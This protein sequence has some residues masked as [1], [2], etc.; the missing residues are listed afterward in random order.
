M[1]L[2]LVPLAP[3]PSQGSSRRF[4]LSI[5]KLILSICDAPYLFRLGTAQKFQGLGRCLGNHGVD[6][7]VRLQFT[8]RSKLYVPT[9][10]ALAGGVNDT[11]VVLLR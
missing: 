2:S 9:A 6:V 5:F 11:A 7:G 8:A 10:N 1:A 4:R 3:S